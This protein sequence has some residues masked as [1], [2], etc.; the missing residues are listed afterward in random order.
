MGNRRVPNVD[1]EPAG[2]A[3][4]DTECPTLSVIV[5]TYNQADPL[6]RTLESLVAQ[7]L[8]KAR[9][10]VLVVDNGSTDHTDVTVAE[11]QATYGEPVIRLVREPRQGLGHARNTG[12]ERSRGLYLAFTDDDVKVPADWLETALRCFETVTPTPW[13]LGGPVFPIYRSPK[14]G[15]FKDEYETHTWG[16]TARFLRPKESFSGG[17]LFIRKD[18]VQRFG[19]F[20]AV[21]GMSGDTLSV[22]EET[23]LF[24][25][26]W[27]ARED[28][29]F[30]YS[31]AM[32]VHHEIGPEKL[33][34]GSPVKRAFAAGDAWYARNGRRSI[35]GRLAALCL[36]SLSAA[37]YA[38][39]AMYR[40]PKH[41]AWQNWATEEL[42]PIAFCMGRMARA[43]GIAVHLSR[44]Q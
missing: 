17:N 34:A 21:V 4:T 33:R 36:S 42:T 24:E 39:R 1:A 31:P 29:R 18:V 11:F 19:G 6:R 30:Y 38:L 23:A 10:E 32:P 43:L 5:C 7:T 41:S 40:F 8:P 22:G 16:D 20:S 25:R 14:P 44:R 2:A 15:W 35:S 28:R 26:I 37:R 13:A 9:Y 3:R 12:V 27:A